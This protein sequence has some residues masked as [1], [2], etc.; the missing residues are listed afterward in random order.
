MDSRSISTMQ[1]VS[2]GC[3]PWEADKVFCENQGR[4]EASLDQ[5]TQRQLPLWGLYQAACGRL[6]GTRG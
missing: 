1:E 6:T 4:E 2:S 5:G 3:G